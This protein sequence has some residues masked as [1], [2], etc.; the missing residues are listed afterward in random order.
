MGK[1]SAI[2][3]WVLIGFSFHA[4]GKVMPVG[5]SGWLLALFMIF[6]GWMF[7][8]AY[9]SGTLRIGIPLPSSSVTAMV[10]IHL[11]ALVAWMTGV[12]LR[13]FGP[14]DFPSPGLMNGTVCLVIGL[15]FLAVLELMSR[16]RWLWITLIV[17]YLVLGITAYWAPQ[18][19]AFPSHESTRVKTLLAAMLGAYLL[20]WL[21]MIV[22]RPKKDSTPA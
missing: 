11:F 16:R 1:L 9:R 19:F 21:T 18:R 4:L 14:G 8:A 17:A 13:G 7:R 3:A 10:G 15:C 20:L 22:T 5:Q 2:A 6:G 12:A